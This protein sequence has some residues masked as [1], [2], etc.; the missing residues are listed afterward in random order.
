MASVQHNN[1]VR[2]SIIHALAFAAYLFTRIA[3]ESREYSLAFSRYT[4]ETA[5]ARNAITAELATTKDQ[6]LPVD[7]DD[8]PNATGDAR[9]NQARAVDTAIIDVLKETDAPAYKSITNGMIV[10][11]HRLGGLLRDASGEAEA[12]QCCVCQRLLL[13]KQEECPC[14]AGS[15]ALRPVWKDDNGNWYGY[16]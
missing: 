8:T 15:A 13:K 3:G 10:S 11:H 5:A 7:Y 4:M 6:W 14:G 12:W 2:S 9:F 16:Y 1:L